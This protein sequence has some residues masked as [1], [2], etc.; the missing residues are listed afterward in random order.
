MLSERLNL[1][2]FKKRVEYTHF[3]FTDLLEKDGLRLTTLND[4]LV[5]MCRENVVGYID[6][7]NEDI[8]WTI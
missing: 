6:E 8:D 3:V 7:E 5:L 2:E 4:T 1:D